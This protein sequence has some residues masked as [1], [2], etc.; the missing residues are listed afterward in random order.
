[1]GSPFHEMTDEELTKQ[2]DE[3]RGELR[4]QRF[5]F[6]VVRSLQDPGKTRKL[7]R[8][9]ARILTVQTERERG[10]SEVQP[11]SGGKKDKAPKKTETTEPQ[12]AKKV[13]KKAAKKTAK[14]TAKK[15]AKK[16]AKKS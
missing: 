13:A 10:I 4:E 12:A 3:F 8:N 2:L 14:K 11:K 1:M 6:A 5:N 9:I 15:A 16:A 7:K